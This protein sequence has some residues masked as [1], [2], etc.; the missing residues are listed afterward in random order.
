[1]VEL[2]GTSSHPLHWFIGIYNN[3]Q[4]TRNISFLLHHSL[5]TS[6]S[7]HCKLTY[8]LTY[9]F[10]MTYGLSNTLEFIL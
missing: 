9:E 4:I 7:S 3:T 6:I 5:S 10:E 1:M 2:G 8:E